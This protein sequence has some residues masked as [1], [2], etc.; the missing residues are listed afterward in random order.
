[1][2]LREEPGRLVIRNAPRF[3]WMLGALSV[4]IGALSMLVAL[5]LAND[6]RIVSLP[7][8][9]GIAVVGCIAAAAGAWICWRAPLST[10]VLDRNR[11]T[12]TVTRRGLFSRTTE[13]YPT[14]AIADV[15]VAKER[16]GRGAPVY[17]LELILV[18]G[19]VVPVPLLRPRDRAGCMRAAER[20]WAALGLPRA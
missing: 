13:Q 20:L 2:R 19:S 9:I 15:R 5:G 1:M 18:C 4:G 8:R 6:S 14:V 3:H 16:D 10:L 17:R 11:Q 7:F 12:L